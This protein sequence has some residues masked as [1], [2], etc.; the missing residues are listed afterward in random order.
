M[1]RRL[2]KTL[3][4]AAYKEEI[5]RRIGEIGP[6]SQRRWGRMTVAEMVCH[7]NVALKIAM[8]DVAASSIS[9]WFTRNVMKH[10]GLWFP[11]EWPHGVETVPECKA[12]AGGRLP[13]AMERDLSELRGLLTR[14]AALPRGHVFPE[15]SIFG[16][17]T[18]REWMRWGYLHMDHHLRQF[19][20]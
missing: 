15:H 17:M 8:G 9:N 2:M 6:N 10:A 13:S 19:G 5:E 18:Y 20:A 7:L 3:A 14:F 12:G 1:A 11:R 4:N 16:R